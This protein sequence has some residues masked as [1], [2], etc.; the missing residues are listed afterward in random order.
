MPTQ[1]SRKSRR[2]VGEMNSITVVCLHSLFE[3]SRRRCNGVECYIAVP[4]SNNISTPYIPRTIETDNLLYFRR[5]YLPGAHPL[6]RS[7]VLETSRHDRSVQ[8]PLRGF[9]DA[10]W[11]GS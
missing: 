9:G 4:Q 2:N 7:G 5:V 3:I 11:A 1:N 8:R 10:T 6:W